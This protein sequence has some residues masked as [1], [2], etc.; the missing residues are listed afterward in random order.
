MQSNSTSPLIAGKPS[1]R[2]IASKGGKEQREEEKEEERKKKLYLERFY[3]R[4][5]AAT[6]RF[7]I[8]E[9]VETAFQW[10]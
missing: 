5:H 7:I 2:T 1:N 3:E 4:S 8:E 9:G 6:Y 10:P